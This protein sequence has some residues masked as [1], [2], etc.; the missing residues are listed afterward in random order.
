MAEKI[1]TKSKIL[2]KAIALFNR[3]GYVNI[4]LQHIADEAELS[5]GNLAYHFKTKDD[6]LESIYLKIEIEQKELLAELR[7]VPLFINIDAHLSNTFQIQQRY[8]FFYSDTFEIIR[9]FPQIKRNYR[10]YTRWFITQLENMLLFNMSRGAFADEKVKGLYKNLAN[11][12]WMSTEL[13]LYQ[14]RIRGIEDLNVENFKT[15]IWSLL[16][17][18]FT[19]IG[20]K[21]YQQMDG[22]ENF[23][24]L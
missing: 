4:R 12:Y 24:W 20:M 2:E 18:Y 10:E 5:V 14:N 17:P 3:F 22:Y 7:L 19:E 8:S 13:W 16:I 21:E 11:Q 15:A 1:N 9:A 6:I 23:N